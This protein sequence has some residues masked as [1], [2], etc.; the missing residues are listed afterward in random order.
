MRPSP[1]LWL[2]RYVRASGPQRRCH[3]A[4]AGSASQANMPACS[5]NCSTAASSPRIVPPAT[6]WASWASTY[7]RSLQLAADARFSFGG[8]DLVPEIAF[9]RR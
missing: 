9:Q 8:V 2:T 5:R 3:L 7:G 6:P 1:G 4:G